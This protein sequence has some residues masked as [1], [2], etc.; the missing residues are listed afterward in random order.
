MN[1]NYFQSFFHLQ[2]IGI[3]SKYEIIFIFS[4]KKKINNYDDFF[5]LQ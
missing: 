4:N 5:F 2:I 1:I 3:V